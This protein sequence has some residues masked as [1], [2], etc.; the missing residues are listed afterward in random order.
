MGNLN[1]FW[2]IAC[3]SWILHNIIEVLTKIHQRIENIHIVINVEL[4]VFV[5]V[6]LQGMV[7]TKKEASE[8][9]V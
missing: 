7:D 1:M 9:F 3:T 4:F 6:S 8:A 2:S 5:C